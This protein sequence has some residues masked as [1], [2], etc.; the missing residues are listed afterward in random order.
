MLLI[1]SA[2]END[3]KVVL[4]RKV[5][6]VAVGL[7][8]VEGSQAMVTHV[9][10]YALSVLSNPRIP[11]FGHDLIPDFHDAWGECQLN[12]RYRIVKLRAQ[13]SDELNGD[14]RLHWNES[15]DFS[16]KKEHQRL[17]SRRNDTNV[18]TGGNL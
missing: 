3:D 11:D 16:E 7:L 5:K 2:D 12:R 4:G 18:Q 15:P 9:T 10:F 6:S 17:F 1:K 13:K 8:P 14:Y